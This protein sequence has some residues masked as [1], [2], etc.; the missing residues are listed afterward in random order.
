MNATLIIPARDEAECIAGVIAEVRRHFT[1][2]VIVVDNG[3]R[4]ATAAVAAA[5]GA[6]VVNE[7]QAGYGRACIS[8]CAAAGTEILV[9]MDGDGSDDPV[10]IPA[11]LAAIEGGAALALGVRRGPGVERSSIA[12]AARFGNWLSGSLIGLFWGH[13]LHDLS[14]FK[15]IRRDALESLDLREQTY[16]WTVEMLAKAAA[17]HLVIAEVQVGYRKRR[18][19][20][21]KVSGN[22]RASAV[23]GYRILRT[24]ARVALGGHM[25]TRFGFLSGMA[26]GLVLT[27]LFGLWL[28]VEGPTST[29]AWVAPWLLLW[30]LALSTGGIGALVASL[31]NRRTTRTR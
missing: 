4:D 18:A 14:P 31:L 27:L 5:A 6:S 3:S 16:G 22:L 1:G 17:Q 10:A 30:P 21:S 19:G 11:L 8:G 9:F 29:G 15:A 25:G 26:I 2:P 23:A 7:P 13:R 28:A 20:E 24:I 12:P